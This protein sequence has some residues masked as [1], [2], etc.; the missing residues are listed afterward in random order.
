M[1]EDLGRPRRLL[2]SQIVTQSYRCRATNL[3]A[4]EKRNLKKNPL[5]FRPCALNDNLW[6]VVNR[7]H[8]ASER[9]KCERDGV[10]WRSLKTYRGYYT[11]ARR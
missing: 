9:K 3:V 8:L 11:A 5:R 10:H 6:K 1:S 7:L 2:T 4:S